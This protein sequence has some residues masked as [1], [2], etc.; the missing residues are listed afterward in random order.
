M[1]G[2]E[3]PVQPAKS[4]QWTDLRSERRRDLGRAAGPA[5]PSKRKRAGVSTGPDSLAFLPALLGGRR[6]SRRFQLGDGLLGSLLL[7][8]GLVA[9]GGDVA[10]AGDGAAG[11]RRDQPAHDHIFLQ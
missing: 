2:E 8:D 9:F 7:L 6:R 5:H 4:V 11:A 1:W 10:Q 3:R